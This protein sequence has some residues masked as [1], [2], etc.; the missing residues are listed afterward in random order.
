[1]PDQ[2]KV[3]VIFQKISAISI[4][5]IIL[6]II[7]IAVLLYKHEKLRAAQDE[8][9]E[10]H[11]KEV[12]DRLQNLNDELEK[13]YDDLLK[14]MEGFEK[15]Y[16]ELERV[17]DRLERKIEDVDAMILRGMESLIQQAFL[18]VETI[19]QHVMD[20]HYHLF[21]PN[22]E[23]ILPQVWETVVEPDWQVSM[24]LWMIEN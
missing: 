3:D 13:L 7:G 14:R 1:M 12:M 15:Q 6:A 8:A 5:V 4:L 23:I 10:K 9:K 16:F 11:H 22:G 2:S 18:H 20:G 24:Q 19:G 21:G 17:C